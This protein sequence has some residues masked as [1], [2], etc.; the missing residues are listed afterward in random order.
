MDVQ[1]YKGY[2]IKS[3]GEFYAVFNKDGRY[4]RN[5]LTVEIAKEYIDLIDNARH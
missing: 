5:A 1:N 4:L 2:A 3:C